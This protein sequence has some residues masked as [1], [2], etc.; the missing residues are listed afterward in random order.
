VDRKLFQT[1]LE[2]TK[3]YDY[4]AGEKS[5]TVSAIKKK[6]YKQTKTQKRRLSKVVFTY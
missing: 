1:A 3:K 5:S 6:Q 2:W 4:D